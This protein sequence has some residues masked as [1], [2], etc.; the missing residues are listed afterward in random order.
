[1]HKRS[2]ETNSM[3]HDENDFKVNRV[4]KMR[5]FHEN[6]PKLLQSSILQLNAMNEFSGDFTTLDHKKWVLERIVLTS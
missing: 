3:V 5:P 1:M 6:L 2:D 4:P